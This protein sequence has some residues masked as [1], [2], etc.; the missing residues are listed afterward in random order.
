M[1]KYVFLPAILFCLTLGSVSAQN[2]PDKQLG[3]V[4]SEQN[5]TEVLLNSKNFEFI[6][7][8]ALPLGQPS[9][10]LVGSNY[11]V[12]FTPEKIISNMPFYGRSYATIIGKDKGLRFKGAPAEFTIENRD[13]SLLARTVVVNEEDTYSILLV[14]GHAGFATMTIS[15]NDR[16]TIDF[17]GEIV[18]I[19]D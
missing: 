19:R 18:S 4:K 2:K 16:Q 17:Q 10:N 12:T 14:V 6:A 9:K 11:S 13:D 5:P 15:T 3:I 7:N 8:T 1:K